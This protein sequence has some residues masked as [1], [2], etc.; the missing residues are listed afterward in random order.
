MVSVWVLGCGGREKCIVQGLERS[1]LECDGRVWKIWNSAV[2]GNL[3]VMTLNFQRGSPG[4]I[5]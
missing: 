3:V 1:V 5:P 2:L 4:S